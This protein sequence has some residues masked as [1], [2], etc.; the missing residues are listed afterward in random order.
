MKKI[1]ACIIILSVI[2]ASGCAHIETFKGIAFSTELAGEPVSGSR[3]AITPGTNVQIAYHASLPEKVTLY[4]IKPA[5]ID[6][7][8]FHD[9]MEYFGFDGNALEKTSNGKTSYSISA[10]DTNADKRELS[11][12]FYPHCIKYCKY[13]ADK[14]AAVTMTEDEMRLA[15][16]KIMRD[17]P[18]VDPAQY[19][20]WGVKSTTTLNKGDTDGTVIV[21][22]GL[23][24]ARLIDG[25]EIS[26]EERFWVSFDSG[27]LCEVN[28]SFFEY[29]KTEEI[30]LIK[31]ENAAERLKTPDTFSLDLET[32]KDYPGG[33]DTLRVM[34]VKLEMVNQCVMQGCEILQPV[35]VFSGTAENQ[36][37]SAHFKARIIAVPQ[38]YTHE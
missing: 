3:N 21:E 4:K 25:M 20:Y 22:K 18:H 9:F 26:G 16:E 14:E 38:K 12:S 11:N 24:F 34:D 35:Y 13:G 15:A 7:A 5:D 1:S 19:R 10:G 31:V 17:I 28:I 6:S 32:G 29:E 36:K 30:K 2:L 27:G 33:A 8:M 37:E 23:F